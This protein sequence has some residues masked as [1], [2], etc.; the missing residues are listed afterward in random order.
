MPARPVSGDR[1]SS[2]PAGLSTAASGLETHRARES[3]NGPRGNTATHRTFGVE[4]YR[5]VGLERD[6]A[7]AVERAGAD[8]DAPQLARHARVD[9][10]PLERARLR[11][12][13]R[14]PAG[15][16]A[17]R[18]RARVRGAGVRALAEH[19][20]RLRVGLDEDE[21]PAGAQDAREL[22]HEA[23]VVGDLCVRGGSVRSGA[24]RWRQGEGCAYTDVHG[25]RVDEVEGRVGVGELVLREVAEL[26]AVC[27]TRSAA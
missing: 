24:G 17:R 5:A 27:A 19:R 14:G 15:R 13:E 21:Q 18:R 12:H 11:V 3:D 20:V 10:E 22:A 6:G 4:P 16:A 2:T 26:E 25:P 1:S 9:A 23:R 7:R 8:D